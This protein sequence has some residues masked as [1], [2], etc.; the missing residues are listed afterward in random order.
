MRKCGKNIVQP[1]MPQTSIWRMRIAHWIPKATNTH[2]ECVI[3]IASPQQQKLC[4]RA[5]MLRYMYNACRVFYY[6]RLRLIYY[7]N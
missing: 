3:R 4:E 1:D 6:L 2:S 5:S 7:C